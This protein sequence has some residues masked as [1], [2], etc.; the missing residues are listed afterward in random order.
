MAPDKEF[1]VKTGLWARL[2]NILRRGPSRPAAAACASKAGQ[3]EVGPAL[4]ASE[5][6]ECIAAYARAGYF[7]MGYVA[8]LFV[9]IPEIPLSDWRDEP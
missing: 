5:R 8:D 7:D 9:F 4:H 1:A 2:G 3:Q 6:L